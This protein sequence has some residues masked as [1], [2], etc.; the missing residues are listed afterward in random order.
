MKSSVLYR[1]ASV[2]LVIFAA[3]HAFGFRQT[4]PSWG[5]D[6][7]LAS[8]QSIHF[9]VF[10]SNRTYWDFFVGFGF[11]VSVFL[12]FA[13][14][15]AWQLGRLGSATLALMRGITWPF[16]MCFVAVTILLGSYVFIVPVVFSAL[17][18]LC[19]IGAAWLTSTAA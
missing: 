4:D 5:V 10:G 6:S 16:A 3:L 17:I 2:L 8:M 15:L 9:E 1:M 12:V 11:V 7:L 13:A 19:L 14:V 18:S